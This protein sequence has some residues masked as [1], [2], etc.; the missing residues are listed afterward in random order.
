M[1]KM[2]CV[3]GRAAAEEWAGRKLVVNECV[4]VVWDFAWE[5][6]RWGQHGLVLVLSV[7][8]MNEN[9]VFYYGFDQNKCI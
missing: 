1:R 8:K 6:D 3:D 5:D 2:G 4:W 7:A 9:V